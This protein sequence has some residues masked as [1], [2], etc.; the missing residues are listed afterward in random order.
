[1]R[2][3]LEV[4]DIVLSR[5][6]IEAQEFTLKTPYTH[7]GDCCHISGQSGDTLAP[8]LHPH[9]SPHSKYCSIAAVGWSIRRDRLCIP[10]STLPIRWSLTA[11]TGPMSLALPFRKI[12]VYQP[13][14]KLNLLLMRLRSQP[15][16]AGLFGPSFI[17]AVDDR[18]VV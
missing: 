12:T 18:E 2:L 3:C 17:D 1:M 9:C 8:T 6:L 10:R 15:F 4:L 5:D 13:L 14:E 11:Y 16:Q 7:S